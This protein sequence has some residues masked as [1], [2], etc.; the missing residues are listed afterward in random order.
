MTATAIGTNPPRQPLSADGL[1]RPIRQLSGRETLAVWTAATA[2]MAL[3]SW[4]IAPRLAPSLGSVGLAKA[5]ILTLCAGLVWQ[6][7]LTMALVGVEQ[8][9]LRWTA[10]RDALWLRRPTSPATGR[11]GGRL[12]WVLLPMTVIFA[13]GMLVPAPAPADRDLG[14]LLGSPAGE[15]WL[16]GAWGWFAVMMVLVIFNTVAGEELLFRGYLLPRMAARFGRRAW[17]VN[18]IAFATYHLHTPWV[19]PGALLDSF[20]LS[21]PSQRYR[22]AWLGIIVHSTQSLLIIGAVLALVMR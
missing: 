20:A 18:G 7:V 2:P 14:A 12:W 1:H 3:A 19:I 22:S 13:S 11:V 17:L 4:V 16:S 5:L 8:R 10:L 15:A 9:T 6:F 21:Y